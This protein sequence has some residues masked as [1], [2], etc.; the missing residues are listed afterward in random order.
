MSA[1]TNLGL[2]GD[3]ERVLDLWPRRIRVS[4][5]FALAGAFSIAEAVLAG[6]GGEQLLDA[7]RPSAL[8]KPL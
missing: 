4:P 1:H 6:G 7:P 5:D 3:D 8:H 2:I